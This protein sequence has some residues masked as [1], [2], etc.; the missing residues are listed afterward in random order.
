LAKLLSG[1]TNGF[2]KMKSR[3]SSKQE[4]LP[5]RRKNTN[6]KKLMTLRVFAQLKKSTNY[7]TK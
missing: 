5:Q 1:S 4:K 3:I 6:W 2:L 7:S